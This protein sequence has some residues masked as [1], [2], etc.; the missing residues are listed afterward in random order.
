[1]EKR[2]MPRKMDL[3]FNT[4][5]YKKKA[6]QEAISAYS[7]LAKFKVED[8]KDYINIHMKD[9]DSSVKDVIADEFANYALGMTKKCL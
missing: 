5:I 1:M 9:I 2:K 8:V 7:S 4:K 3:K 6:I